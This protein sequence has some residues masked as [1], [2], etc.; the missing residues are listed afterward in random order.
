[1]E[2]W[3]AGDKETSS[4]SLLMRTFRLWVGREQ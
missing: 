3:C 2:V 1:M 4:P